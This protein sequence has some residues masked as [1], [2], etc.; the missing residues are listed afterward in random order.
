MGSDADR[1]VCNEDEVTYLAFFVPWL[2]P[3]GNRRVRLHWRKRHKEDGELQVALMAIFNTKISSKFRITESQK[4]HAKR[5][6]EL[7]VNR[8]RKL[9]WDNLVN[10]LKPFVD[11]LRCRFKTY[12]KG[13]SKTRS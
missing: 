3:S 10:G 4:D 2:V 5:R 7:T 12:G 1:T 8:R 11:M 13:K 6:I 9:D